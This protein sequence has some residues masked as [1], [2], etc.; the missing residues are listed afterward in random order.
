VLGVPVGGRVPPLAGDPVAGAG[1]DGSGAVPIGA[2]AGADE[3]GAV[4]VGAETGADGSGTVLGAGDS[5]G[6]EGVVSSFL[7]PF[8][9]P[10]SSF[11]ASPLAVPALLS[12]LLLW[13]QRE[14]SGDRSQRIFMI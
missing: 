11:G 8:I 14:L 4:L 7:S 2:E 6:V 12:G 9:S 3:S 1:I 10:L 13:A 5:L